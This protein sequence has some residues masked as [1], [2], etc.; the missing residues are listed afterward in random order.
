MQWRKNRQID[1]H[2]TTHFLGCAALVMLF[3]WRIEH[4]YWSIPLTACLG[5]LWEWMDDYNSWRLDTTG[6]YIKWLDPAGGDYY[7]L[8]VDG[9]GILVGTGILLILYSVNWLM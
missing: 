7:D 4:L 2:D 3:Q 8:I 1:G 9:L 5:L 6:T